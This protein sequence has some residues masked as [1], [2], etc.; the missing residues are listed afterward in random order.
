[1]SIGQ[2]RVSST[3][4]SHSGRGPGNGTRLFIRPWLF[5][6]DRGGE[7]PAPAGQFTGDGDVGDDPAFVKGFELIPFVMQAVVALVTTDAGAL[8]SCFPPGT[9]LTAD[10]AI[11][12]M[13]AGRRR[14]A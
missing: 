1:M 14:S 13:A 5:L 10:V 6:L 3:L 4:P 2:S 8:V 11:R 7:G 12:E 9:H